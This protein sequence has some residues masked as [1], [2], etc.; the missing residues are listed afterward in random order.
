MKAKSIL[1]IAIAVLMITSMFVVFPLTSRAG[2]LGEDGEIKIGIIGPV[3]LPHWS[4]AGMKEAAEMARDEINAAGGV[5]VHNNGSSYNITLVFGNEYAYPD[6]LPAQAALEMERLVDPGQE[7][8]DFVIGGFR[9]ECT[10]AMIEVAADYGKPFIINGASTNEL[11]TDTVGVNYARYK[12]LFRNNPINSTMLFATIAYSLAYYLIP[13]KLAPIYGHDLDGNAST[14]PQV[15]VAVIS[16]DLAWNQQMHFLLT[17]PAYYPGYLGPQANVTYQGRIPDGTT[18]CTPWL[19]AAM[20][21]QARLIIHIFS[22]VSGVP[23]VGQWRAMGVNATLVGINVLAQMQTHWSTLGG[24]CEYETILDFGGTRTPLVPGVTDVFWDNFMAK[25]GVWPLYTAWGSYDGIYSLKE[26][27]EATG[28]TNKDA[29]VAYWEN[30]AWM[31]LGLNGVFTFT[32]LHDVMSFEPGPTWEYGFVRA[33]FVQWLSERKEVVVPIDQTYT[34]A[35]LFPPWMYPLREDIGQL[36][37][38]VDMRDI[39]AAAAAFGTSPG[40]DRW[41]QEADITGPP[42]ERRPDDKVDMRDIGQIASKFGTTITL[43]LP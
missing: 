20:G 15:R 23:F 38:K 24:A 40:A 42:P 5:D 13:V 9:T 36:D 18:D 4:P 34:K 29:L 1:G 2:A 11:I 25:A 17:N 12:Y 19:S 6:I 27:I 28:T 3:G 16:E 14:P 35:W 43:P 8:C 30:P 31:R 10:T 21:S 37:G 41:N 26:A 22:G 32:D 39:G 33:M 7:N